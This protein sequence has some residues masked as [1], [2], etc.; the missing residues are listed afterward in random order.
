[1]FCPNCG[2]K[3]EDN[4]KFCFK[5]GTPL[6]VSN[7][8]E[9]TSCDDMKSQMMAKGFVL[10]E[11][12]DTAQKWKNFDT[13]KTVEIE[14]ID[15]E[16]CQE[17]VYESTVQEEI[18]RTTQNQNSNPS[19]TNKIIG[20]VITIFVLVA[21]GWVFGREK[22]GTMKYN[23]ALE[24]DNLQNYSKAAELYQDSCDYGNAMGCINLGVLYVNGQGVKQDYAKAFDLSKKGC[25]S[26]IAV[27]CNNL[28]LLYDSGEGVQK[29]YSKAFN[30]FE[31]AC[32]NKDALGCANLGRYYE[33]GEVIK[34][35]N[36]KAAELYKKSCDGD[37]AFGCNSLGILYESG[38]GVTQDYFKAFELYKQACNGGES[39]GC[40]NVGSAYQD[41]L[42]VQK[43]TNKAYEYY[44]KACNQGNDIGC[45]LKKEIESAP[46][47]EQQ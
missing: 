44:A 6:E 14:K 2:T 19:K 20:S 36:L 25:D 34:K 42:G 27:G 5:C 9:N 47:T 39:W 41:G 37:A 21:G 4:A 40:K 12:S 30:L 1:M 7:E 13:G 22:L 35:D 23:D 17:K 3:N 45:D 38:R 32:N 31:K 18:I 8:A 11:E 33:D 26:G 24:A 46:A 10:L 29:D 15:S 43:N 16:W 28:G